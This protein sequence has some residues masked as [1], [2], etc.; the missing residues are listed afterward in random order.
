MSYRVFF[1]YKGNFETNIQGESF[2]NHVDL[3]K[4][5]C[6]RGLAKSTQISLKR[7][8]NKNNSLTFSSLYPV[9]PEVQQQHH[10]EDP[11]SA[12]PELS[13]HCKSSTKVVHG[14]AWSH[15]HHVSILAQVN[16][17]SIFLPDAYIQSHSFL[18]MP[19]S[20]SSKFPCLLLNFV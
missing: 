13:H 6:H 19:V 20:S 7:L 18:M 15:L 17:S 2:V 5:I 11:P 8:S 16:S 3:C 10:C 9:S 14:T 1:S 4:D 12:W